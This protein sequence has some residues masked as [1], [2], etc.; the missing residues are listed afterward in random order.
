[1]I[2]TGTDLGSGIGIGD[3]AGWEESAE[4]K[5]SS[6]AGRIRARTRSYS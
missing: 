6:P 1:M 3:E 5:V 2:A 4:F